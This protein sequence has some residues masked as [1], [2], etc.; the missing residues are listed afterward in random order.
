MWSQP[1]NIS[2]EASP[3]PATATAQEVARVP[4]PSSSLRNLPHPRRNTPIRRARRNSK[5]RD[6][7]EGTESMMLSAGG[8]ENGQDS[9]LRQLDIP[10]PT[11]DLSLIGTNSQATQPLFSRRLKAILSFSSGKVSAPPLSIL[12]FC[13]KSP[14]TQE[15]L[16][17][18]SKFTCC[19]LSNLFL[20][21]PLV[22]TETHRHPVLMMHIQGTEPPS[23]TGVLSTP[24]ASQG[25]W[26][27]V[28]RATSD[29]HTE[30]SKGST[31]T[32]GGNVST[33][34][35]TFPYSLSTFLV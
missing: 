11:G 3:C 20:F 17:V 22:E 9:S 15:M 27:R 13:R 1:G 29:P 16:P 4:L 10:R 33:P 5:Q 19:R 25:S 24:L 28:C 18:T 7:W 2:T 23:S 26:F 34:S 6:H 35:P 21:S 32:L 30:K 8:C 12:P 14:Y 31:V